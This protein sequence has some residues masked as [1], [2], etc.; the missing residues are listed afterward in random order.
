MRHFFPPPA[1]AITKTS[2]GYDLGFTNKETGKQIEMSVPF[3]GIFENDPDR[4]IT[5][6]EVKELGN[7]IVDVLDNY[8]DGHAVRQV[9]KRRARKPKR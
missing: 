5:R 9:L 3:S 1:I 7:L 8:L 2:S 6:K 4:E